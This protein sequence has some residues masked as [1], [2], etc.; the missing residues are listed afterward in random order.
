MKNNF[1]DFEDEIEQVTLY[2]NINKNN[3][4]VLQKEIPSSSQILTEL[5]ND[6]PENSSIVSTQN[7]VNINNEMHNTSNYNQK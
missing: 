1:D 3:S 6:K 7:T 2:T 4:I 5:C